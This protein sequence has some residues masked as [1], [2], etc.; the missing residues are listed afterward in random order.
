MTEEF[1]KKSILQLLQKTKELNSK[2][3]A[4]FYQALIQNNT[5]LKNLLN[6]GQQDASEFL[7][8]FL[9]SI[10]GPLFTISG[11]S[12]AVISLNLPDNLCKASTIFAEAQTEK[13]QNEDIKTAIKTIQDS[14]EEF[15]IKFSRFNLNGKKNDRPIIL[16]D[17]IINNTTYVPV[18]T[19][20]HSGSPKQG[21]YTASI[22]TVDE[23]EQWLYCDDMSTN[24]NICGYNKEPSKNTSPSSLKEGKGVYEKFTPYIIKY[25]DKE[26]LAKKLPPAEK[27]TFI[28]NI[29][30]SCFVNAAIQ[31][32][33]T[34]A[35][36]ENM[37]LIKEEK[38]KDLIPIPPLTTSLNPPLGNEQGS[39]SR[40]T[41]EK[42][43]DLIPIPPLTTSLNPPLGNGQGSPSRLTGEKGKD[44][45]PIPPLTTSLNPPLG[46]EQGDPSRLTGEKGKD[47]IPIPP[48]T[49]S[50]N[51][52]LGNEQGDP[53]RLTGEKG[54]DLIPIP[55]LTASPNPPLGNEQG[56]PSRLTGEKGKDLI[57][58]PPLTASPNPLLGNGQGGPSRLTGYKRGEKLGDNIQEKEN[59][60]T[61]T[62][63]VI[64][65]AFSVFLS[66][67][68]MTGV[69]L[70]A[71]IFFSALVGIP[72]I[73]LAFLSAGEVL[74]N[75]EKKTDPKN[76][77]CYGAIH[78]AIRTGSMGIEAS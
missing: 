44:L 3:T 38:G 22:R 76:S 36:Q 18:A 69:V 11:L 63:P 59:S 25:V 49:T 58:I 40:L 31:M 7:S 61:L 66:F 42:G 50:L 47:L 77:T 56:D 27:I 48:L 78:S 39:P 2:E 45:I 73:F 23:A 43:K 28:Q 60:A 65:G 21:H 37:L 53:S 34:V 52:P 17:I 6:T 16:D 4:S 10:Y 46:N 35:F 74:S 62:S 15:F 26:K 55:P 41:G 64:F 68:L 33:R 29:D 24:I 71:G 9:V 72:A 75:I 70:G 8:P 19:I 67:F 57:P 54:K 20:N 30:N 13:E 51:P 12:S 5:E 1:N 32:L 14:T